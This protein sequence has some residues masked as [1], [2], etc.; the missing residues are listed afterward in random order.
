MFIILHNK[1]ILAL[2][3]KATKIPAAAPT[4][5][6][7]IVNPPNAAPLLGLALA[8]VGELVPVP[9]TIAV[10]VLVTGDVVVP[11]PMDVIVEDSLP[12][13]VV[14]VVKA[15]TDVATLETEDSGLATLEEGREGTEGTEVGTGTGRGVGVVMVVLHS[16][17][18]DI[19][20]TNEAGGGEE[21]TLPLSLWWHLQ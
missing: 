9:V 5:P 16:A 19:S 13:V 20:N 2:Q 15:V 6:L 17:E 11:V 7:S 10:L 21:H 8:V 1:L 18:Y 14:V 12:V 4:S 3:N